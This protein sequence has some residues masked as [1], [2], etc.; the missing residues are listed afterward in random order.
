MLS[1][2]LTIILA[3][4]WIDCAFTL[5]VS[6][7]VQKRIPK[8]I[9]RTYQMCLSV[10]MTIAAFSLLVFV[11]KAFLL[12]L[13]TETAY[14]WILI[15]MLTIACGALGATVSRY[16]ESLMPPI[17]EQSII[18]HIVDIHFADDFDEDN[19]GDESDK[20]DESEA[21]DIASEAKE[22]TPSEE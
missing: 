15:G 2:I 12:T 6:L 21:A 11:P 3:L 7:F 4:I 17:T 16:C 13:M 14:S 19:D 18:K 22:E 8:R 10:G 5:V 9:I 20:G 1:T